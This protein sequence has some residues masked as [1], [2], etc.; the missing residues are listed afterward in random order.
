LA[1]GSP[2]KK[3]KTP[4]DSFQTSQ[5]STQNGVPGQNQARNVAPK[6]QKP[7][8]PNHG[9]SY[10]NFLRRLQ[11]V[12]SSEVAEYNFGKPA[13]LHN[14]PFAGIWEELDKQH[15]FLSSQIQTFIKA[16]PGATAQDYAHAYAMQYDAYARVGQAGH[17]EAPQSL[18]SRVNWLANMLNK[19]YGHR[20][21]LSTPWDL[22]HPDD[23]HLLVRVN[24]FKTN[25]PGATEHDFIDD[26]S[27]EFQAVTRARPGTVMEPPVALSERLN[28]VTGLLEYMQRH[29]IPPRL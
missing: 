19:A 5:P 2:G 3:R 21:P 27:K 22:L 6:R 18:A 12:N 10:H 13:N 20:E 16:N 1:S 14:N 26:Y 15:H 11:Q 24:N 4:A 9:P 8:P 17:M 25:N 23:Q 29:H 28:W 7:S